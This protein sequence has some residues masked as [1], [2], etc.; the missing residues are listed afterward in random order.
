MCHLCKVH[1]LSGGVRPVLQNEELYEVSGRRLLALPNR[2]IQLLE[3][4]HVLG[5]PQLAPDLSNGA[6]PVLKFFHNGHLRESVHSAAPGRNIVLCSVKDLVEIESLVSEI[7]KD[8][9][10]W[11]INWN[12]L[13]YLIKA[14]DVGK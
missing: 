8:L 2:V 1:D 6:N 14:N 11:I 3:V 12:P 10:I 4:L 5:V 7:S 9:T 13:D